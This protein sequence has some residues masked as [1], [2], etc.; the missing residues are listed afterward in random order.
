MNTSCCESFKQGTADT[1]RM[2]PIRT[3]MYSEI[4]ISC[5]IIP[6]MFQSIWISKKNSGKGPGSSLLMATT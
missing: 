4:K 2:L 6:E 5:R 1:R 3:W